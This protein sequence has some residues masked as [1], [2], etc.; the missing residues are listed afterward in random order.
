[1]ALKIPLRLLSAVRRVQAELLAGDNSLADQADVP[2][3]D[4]AQA[5]EHPAASAVAEA[6]EASADGSTVTMPPEAAMAALCGEELFAHCNARLRAFCSP[7]LKHPPASLR[8]HL[9][10][11]FAD[12]QN[13]I[14]ICKRILSLGAFTCQPPPRDANTTCCQCVAA[15]P[16]LMCNQMRGRWQQPGCTRTS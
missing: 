14:E 11:S 10:N 5:A 13:S 6:A 12:P 2:P 16:P 9:F 15:K 8:R 7:V 3:R 1:M 4:G